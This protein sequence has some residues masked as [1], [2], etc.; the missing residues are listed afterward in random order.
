MRRS[1]GYTDE[2]EKLTWDDS[3]LN[4]TVRLKK[5]ATRKMRLQV[6][7]YPQAEYYYILSNKGM[8]MCFKNYSIS[9]EIDIA[10]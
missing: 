3:D 9:K 7:S 1:K 2:F 5:A 6:T 10:A 4:V 8:I